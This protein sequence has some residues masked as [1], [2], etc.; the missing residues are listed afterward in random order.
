KSRDRSEPEEENLMA[1]IVVTESDAGLDAEDD[2]GSISRCHGQERRRLVGRNGL[3][4][5]RVQVEEPVVHPDASIA[6]LALDDDGIWAD[7]KRSIADGA[8][9]ARSPCPHEAVRAERE[10]MLV[11]D[12]HANDPGE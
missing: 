9:R 8:I 2:R 10:R 11:S 12:S 4:D 6:I 1:D 5:G 3:A 7:S